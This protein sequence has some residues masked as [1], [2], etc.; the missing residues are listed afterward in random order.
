MLASPASRSGA[1][2]SVRALFGSMALVSFYYRIALPER[3]QGIGRRQDGQDSCA[4]RER[5]RNVGANSWLARKPVEQRAPRPGRQVRVSAVAERSTQPLLKTASEQGDG[6]GGRA[7][8]AWPKVWQRARI[9]TLFSSSFSSSASNN[10]CAR[11]NLPTKSGI[12]Q[13]RREKP[14]PA[15]TRK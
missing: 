5:S 6:A 1:G 12:H 7:P 4:K 9:N 10:V 8:S 15:F 3:H 2:I 13:N 11:T 14:S